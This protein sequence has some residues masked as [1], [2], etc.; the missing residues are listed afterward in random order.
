MDYGDDP[1]VSTHYADAHTYAI[2]AVA[3]TR[4]SMLDNIRQR[5]EWASSSLS[6]L[7][8]KSITPEML[9]ASGMRWD[10]LNTT[11]GVDA[12]IA[13]GFRWPLMIES[14][15]T[16]NHLAT[17]SLAQ[18]TSLGL[19]AVRMMECRPRIE[20]IS[21]LGLNAEQM[22][23]MGWSPELLTAIGL[24][25]QSMVDFGFP[26]PVWRDV[27]GVQD[28]GAL[29]FHNYSECARMGWCDSE[30]RLALQLSSNRPTSS[31]AKAGG[32]IRFL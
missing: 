31:S 28:F 20:H 14:G 19:T 22:H 13:F 10:K 23:D 7:K 21:A 12:A 29:G 11:H 17:L 30:I 3:P 26:L 15:F 1:I 25:M 2:N 16:G 4:R 9:V 27:L 24:S 32:P 8:D 6:A 18:I 5:H